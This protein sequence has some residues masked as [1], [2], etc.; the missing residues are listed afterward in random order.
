MKHLAWGAVLAL[1]LSSSLA[2][3]T[4]LRDPREVHLANLRQLTFGGENAEAY[5]TPDGRE[6]TFQST[7]PTATV[8]VIGWILPRAAATF[9]RVRHCTVAGSA[10]PRP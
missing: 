10:P 4:N 2:A 9:R 7:R 8:S 1:S 3:D 6:V 5:W